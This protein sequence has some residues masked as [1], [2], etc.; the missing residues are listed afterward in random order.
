MATA[1][2][3]QRHPPV[4]IYTSTGGSQ[5]TFLARNSRAADAEYSCDDSPGEEV[6]G[7]LSELQQWPEGKAQAMRLSV[8]DKPRVI[9]CA[10]NFP[11]HIGLPRG[12]M[13]AI[14]E[15]A[16]IAMMNCDTGNF[17]ALSTLQLSTV[18]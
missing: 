3:R 11:N 14:Q 15:A 7:R 12:C 9:G 1:Q 13:D 5:R 17:C 2:G 4:G 8:W 10:E 18:G 16:V 6:T